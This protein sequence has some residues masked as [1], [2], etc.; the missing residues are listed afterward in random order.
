M[1]KYTF[2]LK[3]GLTFKVKAKGLEFTTNNITGQITYYSFE[4]YENI[5]AVNLSEVVAIVKDL[6]D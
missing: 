2:Y 5:F 4:E 6:E 1:N 3:N